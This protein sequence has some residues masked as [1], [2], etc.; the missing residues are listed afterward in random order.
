MEHFHNH[1]GTE[2]TYS[3]IVDKM[4]KQ[5]KSKHHQDSLMNIF[6]KLTLK[7]L[8]AEHNVRDQATAPRLTL[9]HLR[10]IPLFHTSYI[11]SV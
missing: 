11:L 8:I 3:D 7:D 5:Y 2:T 10:L 9:F 4:R 1:I 6:D